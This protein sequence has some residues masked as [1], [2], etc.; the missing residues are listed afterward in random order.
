MAN[1]CPDRHSGA[2]THMVVM[3]AVKEKELMVASLM[4]MLSEA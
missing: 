4:R 2:I 1:G 3:S